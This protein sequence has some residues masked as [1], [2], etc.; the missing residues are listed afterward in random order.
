MRESLVLG[1]FGTQLHEFPFHQILKNLKT[2]RK[3]RS[4]PPKA[5]VETRRNVP[6]PY[7]EKGKTKNSYLLQSKGHIRVLQ[8]RYHHRG[9]AENKCAS[10]R[11]LKKRE[12][13][14]MS[15]SDERNR[16]ERADFFDPRS[17]HFITPLSG[18]V[19]HPFTRDPLLESITHLGRILRRVKS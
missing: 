6:R 14:D 9:Y 11:R 7:E 17:L 1:L 12:K 18:I 8:T 3:H 15:R 19:C 10:V 5:C 13:R 2:R 4:T 16:K